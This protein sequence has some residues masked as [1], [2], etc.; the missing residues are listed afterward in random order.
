MEVGVGGR[1]KVKS[2][3]RACVAELARSRMHLIYNLQILMTV[4]KS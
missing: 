2:S 3:S 4:D 1:N